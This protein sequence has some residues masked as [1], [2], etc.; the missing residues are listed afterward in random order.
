LQARGG[1]VL[2][3]PAGRYYLDR[4]VFVTADN[5]VLRGAG[6]DRT[7]FIARFTM[8]GRAPEF[9]DVAPGGKIGPSALLT[10][11]V[12][13]TGLTGLTLSSGT[14]LIQ[15]IAQPGIWNTVV[16]FSYAGSLLLQA[17]GPG[18][19]NLKA[20]ATYR[21]GTVRSASQ[22]VDLVQAEV[23]QL[24][25]NGGVLGMINFVGAGDASPHHILLAADG[26]R[27]AMSLDLPPGHGLK[28][29][30]RIHLV[31]PI[32]TRWRTLL[33]TSK[34]IDEFRENEYQIKSVAGNR[35][36]LPEALRI[37]FPIIDGAYVQKIRPLMR[38]GIEDLGF[39][40][41][42]PT[43]VHS[44]MFSSGWECWVRGLRVAHTGD[45]AV[46]M[47]LSK[48]CEVRDCVFERA[49]CHDGG[50]AYV[51]WED[52]FDC[53]MENVTT[54]DMRHA[55]VLQWAASGN[56]IR[57][58]VFHGSDAQWHAGWTNENL[59][60]NL[61]VE[62]SEMT[63]AY[64]NG[65]WAS[66]PDD[67]AHGPNGPR[68]VVYNCN[69]TSPRNGLWLGGMNEGWL[70]LHNRFVAGMGPAVFAKDASFDHIF[71]D[72]VFVTLDPEPAAVYLAT[73]DCIGIEFIGNRFYG[74]RGRIFGG[75]IPP[76]VNRDNWSEET[77]GINRP[78][79]AVPSIFE[80]EQA[81]RARIDAGR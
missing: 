33:R 66:G 3:I 55:P 64:G 58:S 1:G 34:R 27:G 63:G 71:W 70:I 69:F 54:Y 12:D 60:E 59:Y 10:L 47:P 52:S 17:A 51:G 11:W 81:H 2:L 78:R 65:G 56:V 48:R 22:R 8:R 80:W 26:K 76:A 74:A 29:G 42:V 40:Q 15:A 24:H 32:T 35:V 20:V 23:P 77:G 61:V 7:Q 36:L 72:N 46:Y 13:P 30:D 4:P 31:A 14:K 19:A 6:A 25:S 28:A 79:P 21:N 37:D 75:A 68:N 18:P 67:A 44:V 38:C 53:L 39:E 45:K 9:H 57:S 73:P 5:C 43:N 49:W 41:V 62:S 50:F 16:T